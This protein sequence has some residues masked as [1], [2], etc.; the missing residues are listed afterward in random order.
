MRGAL[1]VGVA[2][3][4][5][6]ATSSVL[7]SGV[8]VATARGWEPATPLPRLDVIAEEPLP[9][10]RPAAVTLRSVT[11]PP[12]PGDH[13]AQPTLAWIVAPATPA[14]DGWSGAVLVHAAGTGGR[15]DLLPEARALA[16]VGVAAIVYAKR[17]DGYASWARDF[18]ALA[19]DAIRAADVLRR[20]PGMNR[21]RVGVLGWSEGGWV[22]TE[23]V[24]RSA[25]RL[26]FVGLLSAPVVPPADQANWA[27]RRAVPALPAWAEKTAA[28]FLGAGRHLQPWLGHDSSRLVE[29]GIPV[30]GVWGAEDPIVPVHAAVVTLGELASTEPRSLHVLPGAGHELPV[31]SRYLERTARW[32]RALGSPSRS[33]DPAVH[34][35][36][37]ASNLGLGRL[38]DPSWIS[39]PLLQFAICLT[40]AAGAVAVHRQRR[41]G[42]R[43]PTPSLFT[44]LLGGQS[45]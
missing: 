27:L 32:V 7:L 20:S 12:G 26:S 31:E 15:D 4:V 35:A 29:L 9:P 17:T 1:A 21:D 39:H 22:A 33:S 45:R 24:R 28:T 41:P 34:G 44:S 40:L 18:G 37:P 8:A 36:R 16:A 5:A 14:A 13:S 10:A 42:M 38:P 11:I 25:G 19:D 2:F 6:F 30:M 23:A 3:V 43:V